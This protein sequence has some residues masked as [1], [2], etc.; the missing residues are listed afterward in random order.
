LGAV[1][2]LTAS[3]DFKLGDAWTREAAVAEQ[4]PLGLERLPLG[5]KGV[6]FRNAVHEPPGTSS[7]SKWFLDIDSPDP[8]AFAAARA[9]AAAKSPA[10]AA[11]PVIDAGCR[12]GRLAAWLRIPALPDGRIPNADDIAAAIAANSRSGLDVGIAISQRHLPHRRRR[13]RAGDAPLRRHPHATGFA[14]VYTARSCRSIGS[15]S[16]KKNRTRDGKAPASTQKHSLSC[17]LYSGTT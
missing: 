15:R 3:G 10:G 17:E 11:F 4:F 7:L 5:A 9:A 14:Y 6:E 1:P 12:E 8:A 13:A 16:R 2:A